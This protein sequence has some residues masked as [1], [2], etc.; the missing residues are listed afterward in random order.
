MII[1]VSGE[2]LVMRQGLL[3]VFSGPSGVGKGTV[4]EKLLHDFGEVEYSISA[5]TRGRRQGEVEGQDYFFLSKEDFF[6]KVEQEKFIEW[7]KVHNNYYGTP[8]DYVEKTMSEGKDVILEI[9]IQGARQVKKLY[10]DAVYI[11]L[12][13][14]SLK[15]LEKRLNKRGSENENDKL[16]R[17][18]N[19]MM[20][21]QEKINYD[22][23]IINDL[24]DK[25]ADKLKAIII[26]ERCRIRN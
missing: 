14:P 17:I 19:A 9:D 7:A 8:R 26:A 5:T 18:Q 6:K 23:E 2:E 10:Q 21:M 4:L 24:V 25:A 12:S 22:Y 11:F 16:V 3:F 13:P 15:E 20:E 1:N